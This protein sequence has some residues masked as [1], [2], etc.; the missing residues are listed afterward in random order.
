M[1][2]KQTSNMDMCVIATKM[3][4]NGA[5][6]TPHPY[7]ALQTLTPEHI[8]YVQ[9]HSA[10]THTL[11]TLPITHSHIHIICKHTYM[12]PCTHL[13]V[14]VSMYTHT[15]IYMYPYTH[16]HVFMYTHTCIHV[17]TYM[18]MYPYTHIHVFMYTHTCIHLHSYMYSC[19]HIHVSIY[20]HTCIHLHSYVH[21]SIYRSTCSL[22][23]PTCIHILLHAA[24]EE[25]P[26]SRF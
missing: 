4:E 26:K 15:C 19:T 17:H 2:S 12:Y 13:H 8:R 21:V 18:Y 7:S 10:H 16:I 22:Y 5:N 24:I 20:T 3:G 11:S 14:H 25:V 6:G 9:I 23:T 1:V